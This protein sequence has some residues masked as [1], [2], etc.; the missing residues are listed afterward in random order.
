MSK[1]TMVAA[2]AALAGCAGMRTMGDGDF[3][4]GHWAGEIDRNGSAQPFAVDIVRENGAYSGQ[5]RSTAAF[6]TGS[7]ENVAVRGDQVSFETDQLRFVGAVKGSTLAGTVTHKPD[8][9][10]A[11]EFS[12]TDKDRNEIHYSPASEWSP[13]DIR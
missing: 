9:A 6:G 2:V 1:W 7:L 3:A 11:G 10:P 8:D 12:V 13:F 4:S 5:V